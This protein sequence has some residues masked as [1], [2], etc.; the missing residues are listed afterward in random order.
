MFNICANC[1][2]CGKNFW[3]PPTRLCV[4]DVIFR[5]DPVNGEKTWANTHDFSFNKDGACPCYKRIW[6]KFWV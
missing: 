5:I 4:R 2:Y 1:K 3:P 6:W